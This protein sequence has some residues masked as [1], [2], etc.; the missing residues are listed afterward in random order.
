MP[1]ALCPPTVTLWGAAQTPAAA[2]KLGLWL[3][4]HVCLSL[5]HPGHG[6]P[7]VPVPPC[8]GDAGARCP[9]PSCLPSGNFLLPSWL[10]DLMERCRVAILPMNSMVPKLLRQTRGR[11]TTPSATMPPTSASRARVLVAWDGT[12]HCD[13]DVFLL[14]LDL[15]PPCKPPTHPT[16]HGF[17][18]PRGAVRR[19][20]LLCRLQCHQERAL[21]FTRSV[22]VLLCLSCLS[23]MRPCLKMSALSPSWWVGGSQP[24]AS[25][26]TAQR[27]PL[28]TEG[29]LLGAQTQAHFALAEP[30]VPHCPLPVAVWGGQALSAP[31]LWPP[32]LIWLLLMGV[33]GK[34]P[35]LCVCACL[36]RHCCVIIKPVTS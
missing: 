2:H 26:A 23:L 8:W 4:F 13:G 10:P 19:L 29:W 36:R 1:C 22:S 12:R 25:C 20:S 32:A 6:V 16:A 7:E 31:S 18:V 14:Q 21:S 9:F 34:S 33:P 11:P 3:A 27:H 35:Y 24:C 17:A 28:C 5:L 30:L 15:Q